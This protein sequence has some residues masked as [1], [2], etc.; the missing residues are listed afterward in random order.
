MLLK[1]IENLLD[2]KLQPTNER[3][4]KMDAKISGMNAKIVGMDAKLV[5]IQA[6]QKE[7]KLTQETIMKFITQADSEFMKLEEKTRDIE[8]IKRVINIS[9]VR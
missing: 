1:S 6:T 5:E 8:K 4:D 9:N 7:M 2:K 3:L